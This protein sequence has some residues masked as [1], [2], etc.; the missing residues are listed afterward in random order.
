MPSFPWSDDPETKISPDFVT[1]AEWCEPEEMLCAEFSS[2][3]QRIA[4]G[5]LMLSLELVMPNSPS[6][7]A[8]KQRMNFWLS[9]M[10]DVSFLHSSWLLS[11]FDPVSWS[12]EILFWFIKL[13]FSFLSSDWPLLKESYRIYGILEFCENGCEDFLCLKSYRFEPSKS[14]LL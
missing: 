8:P 3:V 6:L 7:F 5:S 4:L 13:I 11:Y 9:W 10:Y 2:S 14:R 1:R 12:V